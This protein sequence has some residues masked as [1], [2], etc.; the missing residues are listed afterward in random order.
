MQNPESI[1]K[2]RIEKYSAQ[3]GKLI[4]QLGLISFLRLLSFIIAL[5]SLIFLTKVSPAAGIC[6]LFFFLVCF[7][8]LVKRYQ[9]LSRKNT[10]TKNLLQVNSEELSSL[11]HIYNQFDGGAEFINPSHPFTPDLDIFGAG[12][13]FQYLNRTTT[14][15]GKQILADW[16]SFPCRDISIILRTQ[17]AVR[18]L[19]TMTDNRQNFRAT[20]K[21]N[22]ETTSEMQ[23]ILEWLQEKNRYYRNIYYQIICYALPVLTLILLTANII[24]HG[25]AVYVVY[26]FIMQLLF[27]AMHLRYNNKVHGKMGKKL[28]LFKKYGELFRYIEQEKYQS[29]R[30]SG[31]QHQLK[32]DV[33]GARDRIKRLSS[34]ISAFDNRLNILAGV[35]LNGFLLWD[36]QCVMRLEKWKEKNKDKVIRWF[37]ALGEYDALCS[38]SNFAFNHPEFVFPE[39]DTGIILDFKQTGHPLIPSDS[40]IDNDIQIS[41]LGEFVIITGANMAGKS[42]FLRTVSVNLILGMAGAPVCARDARFCPVEIFS[43]MRT[44]D[45]LQKNESYFYAE[46]KR[47]SELFEKLEKGKKLFIVLDEI[48]KGTNS[49]DKQKGSRVVLEKIIKL[50]GAGLIATHDL[51]LAGLEKKYPDNLKNKCFEIELDGDKIQFDYKLYDGITKRMNALLLMQQMGIISDN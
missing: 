15:K 35:I 40:R 24:H 26:L 45:S 2:E 51:D 31:I 9:V 28:E 48:L 14:L 10:H 16:L 41:R 49:A 13:V 19:A 21:M 32:S 47:L 8:L 12:S 30:I 3:S 42:T 36:I 39:P 25:F 38:L 17:E 50:N 46:L 1:Y 20:G 34:I 18:E 33:Q 4:K 44:S 27:V 11:K 29:E 43:S 6:T 22:Q 37:S 23:H 5:V 7:F